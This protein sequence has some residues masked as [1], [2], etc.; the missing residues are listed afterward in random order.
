L[1]FTERARAIWP[2]VGTVLQARLRR[3]AEDARRLAGDGVSFRLCKGIY[4]EPPSLAFESDEEIRRSYMD[5]LD[6]LLD[7]GSHVAVATH[8]RPL[9]ER[10][11][12]L[13]ARRAVAEE[14]FEFQALL[15]V[16]VRAT[17]LRLQ[18]RG[19]TVRLYVPFGADWYAYGVRRLRENPKLAGSIA[20]SL[21]SRERFD[22]ERGALLQ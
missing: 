17:L 14:R 10:V 22:V 19:H 2:R 3:T 12:D 13:L 9:I 8:D 16:P 20:A 6:T 15:G 5:T 4:P 21:F 7:R 18:E 11:E 1:D